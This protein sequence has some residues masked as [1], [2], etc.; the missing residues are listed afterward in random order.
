GSFTADA[1]V[2]YGSHQQPAGTWS[3]DTSLV[4]A[5]CAS[6]RDRGGIDPADM[7]R[8]FRSWLFEGAY[9]ADGQTFDVGHATRQA[10]MLGYGLS[11][12]FSNGNGSLMRILPLA[13]TAADR[14]DIQAVSSITH[15]HA[16][17]IEAC[18]IYIDIARQLLAGRHLPQILTGLQVSSAFSR[19]K[20][21]AQLPQTAIRSSGYVVDTLEAALWCLLQT[22]AYSEAVLKAVN[23]GDDTDTVASVTGGLAG[24][25]YGLEAIPQVWLQQ[26]RNRE[27][28]DSCLF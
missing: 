27:L 17:S 22:T 25:I 11:D 3:D 16:L 23:L 21:L 12:V 1:M 5:T 6:I 14:A 28:L 9:T 10:L 20:E 13:F 24:L 7:Q 4:L 26:L 19:L 15:A 8:R 18:Q 2:G